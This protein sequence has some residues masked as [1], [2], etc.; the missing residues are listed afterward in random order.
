MER[1]PVAL[2]MYT[3]RDEAAKDYLG[4]VRRVAAMG[5]RG[6]QTH[7]KAVDA[8]ALKALA[9]ELDIAVVGMHC[10]LDV[11]RDDVAAAAAFAKGVGC[12][13]ITC[14][15]LAGEYQCEDGFR[16]AADI[17]NKAGRVLKQE[18]L[19]LSYHN[20]SFEFRDYGGRLGYDILFDALD[21]EVV[22]AELDVYWLQHGRQDPLEYIRRFS[23]RLPLLH[24]KDMEPGEERFF[25]EIGEGILDWKAIFAAAAEAGVEWAIVEQDNW[26]RPQME[27]A[28]LSLDNLKKMGL[29]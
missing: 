15:Y 1:I 12:R 19:R 27:S 21:P 26:R 3:V 11:L 28:K 17:M 6:I 18:G 29:A 5:Y 16:K 14:P 7:H 13:D 24:I 8:Q 4:T 9:E 20:H 25:A 23:G 2:T 22:E 10:P